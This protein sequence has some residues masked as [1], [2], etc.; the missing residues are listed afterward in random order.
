MSIRTSLPIIADYNVARDIMG[1]NI[2]I[3]VWITGDDEIC[4]IIHDSL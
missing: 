4:E 1:K 3:I 2:M